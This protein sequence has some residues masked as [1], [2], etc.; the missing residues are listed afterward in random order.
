MKERVR[1]KDKVCPSERERERV[2][3]REIHFSVLVGTFYLTN[4]CN[5]VLVNVIHRIEVN[6]T[7]MLVRKMIS[8]TDKH[9]HKHELH[10]A[11]FV[12]NE[13]ETGRWIIRHGMGVWLDLQYQ[14]KV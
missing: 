8:I 3:E 12:S 11:Q 6:L 1:W 14:S 5:K 13:Y 4:H 9:S 7:D 2:R 10:M